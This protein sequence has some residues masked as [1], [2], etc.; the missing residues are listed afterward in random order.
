MLRRFFSGFSGFPPSI[1][2]NISK[3][4]LESVDEER[5]CGGATA[6]SNLFM[7]IKERMRVR[8]KL[9]MHDEV[10]EESGTKSTKR[11]EDE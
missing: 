5:L 2:T 10:G 9:R 3:S 7:T 4:H 1:K 8:R 11:N 6:N